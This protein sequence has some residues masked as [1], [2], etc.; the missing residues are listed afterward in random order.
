M[1]QRIYYV[2][3]H[4]QPSEDLL[5]QIIGDFSNPPWKVKMPCQRDETN[6]LYYHEVEVKDGQSISFKFILKGSEFCLSSLYGIRQDGE[7][8]QIFNNVI[9]SD[10]IITPVL[11][12]SSSL[13]GNQ[14]ASFT[15]WSAAQIPY[16]MKS[17]TFLRSFKF[18]H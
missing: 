13:S 14:P 5:V 16:K 12:K 2:P 3:Y 4:Q 17:S 9:Q 10:P 1:K 8:C 7:N 18:I 11:S 15:A 6:D